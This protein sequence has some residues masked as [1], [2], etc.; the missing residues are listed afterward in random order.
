MKYMKEEGK[1]EEGIDG[2]NGIDKGD[3]GLFQQMVRG[4]RLGRNH[5]VCR[6]Q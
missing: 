4:G 6:Y 1:A 3:D 2:I 5:R